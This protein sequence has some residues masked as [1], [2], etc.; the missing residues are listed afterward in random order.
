MTERERL[1]KLIDDG[2]FKVC[3]KKNDDVKVAHYL[4]DHLLKNG[5]IVPPV[6]VGDTV[7]VRAIENFD[8][9]KLK[10]K[11]IKA[12]VTK[13]IFDEFICSFWA[14]SLDG[15]HC[16]KIDVNDIGQTVFLTPEDAEKALKE[17]EKKWDNINIIQRRLPL[18]MAKS[19][20]K[21]T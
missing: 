1:I 16:Y 7:Y 8:I 9:V 19:R 3:K 4:A 20:S 14:N 13:F 11:I 18:R 15:N 21:S 10:Y 12:K 6:S 17:R 2:C 5:V